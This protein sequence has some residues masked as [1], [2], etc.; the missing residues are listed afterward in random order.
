ME[1]SKAT[2]AVVAASCIT[3]GAA[4]AFLISRSA[5]PSPAS[6][7]APAAAA[8][9]TNGV[10]QSED[11]VATPPS[12]PVNDAAPVTAPSSRVSAPVATPKNAPRPARVV[13][14]KT[15][16]IAAASTHAGEQ[17]RATVPDARPVAQA[18]I[19]E[20]PKVAAV[21]PIKP[22]TPEPP[23]IVEPPKPTF[24]DL[25]V[26]TDSVLGLQM[27][28]SVSSE[29][30]R[31][32][33]EVVARVTRD[34][35]VGDRVAIPAGARAYG[36][37]TLVDRGG[38]VKD[39]ARLGI[40]FTSV[41]LADGSRVPLETET[42]YRDGESPAGKSAAKIGG[43]AIGGAI[44][45]GIFGGAKGAVLG[46]T[47]GGGAGTAAV[48]AGGREA[49]TLNAGTPVTVRLVKPATVTIEEH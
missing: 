45:G 37:V 8:T 18:P 31:V 33:D 22:S 39:A 7:S 32:E 13:P 30:A 36:N 5:G 6:Q 40:K 35:R 48:M 12:S 1:I 38:K 19:A 27:E 21:E 42:I 2:I 29:R 20:A 3:V 43:G 14:P 10:E 44:L 9:P 15:A 24:T 28:T 41:V 23:A 4:G 46:A 16:P 25:V 17:A 26:A 49:A 47:A 34:V 11:V